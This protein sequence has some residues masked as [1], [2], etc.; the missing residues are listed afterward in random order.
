MKKYLKLIAILATMS[1]ILIACSNDNDKSKIKSN[2]ENSSIKEKQNNSDED[3]NQASEPDDTT[4]ESEG[5]KTDSNEF[6]DKPLNNKVLIIS[7]KKKRVVYYLP[8]LLKRL[9]ML[10]FGYN[11]LKRGILK[12]YAFSILQL[13]NQ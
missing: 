5:N 13:E 4:A 6:N 11:L 9:S 12:N 10:A 2:S 8:I 1:F 3:D 7:Q